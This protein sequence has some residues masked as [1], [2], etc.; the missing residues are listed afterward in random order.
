MQQKTTIAILGAGNIGISIANGLVQSGEFSS[1]QITLTRRKIHF[2]EEQKN[3]GYIIQSDN[4][5]AV[6]KSKIIIISVEPQQI[7][8]VL[9][10]IRSELVPERHIVISVVTGVWIK[11]I[12]AL[13]GDQISVVRAMPN[14]AI[15]IRKS[16]TCL[17]SD[18]TS[19]EALE[20]AKSIFD[21]VGETLV[22]EEEQMIAATALGA[23]GIAFF[24]R[25]IRAASQGGIE[26]GFDS[27]DALK[28]AVQAALGAASLL[29]NTENHPEYEI[30]K[31]TT[32]RGC[33]I[34]GLNQMEQA[35]FSAAMIKGITASA[36]KASSLYSKTSS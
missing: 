29:L 15:S 30:D 23:C 5:E 7:N 19:V 3:K 8:N 22:M 16:M 9:K 18:E 34:L 14:T 25:A 27:G 20:T 6:K 10:E 11:Q 24:L 12:S 35:G 1:E 28:I 2:L 21:S 17:S 31:V 26:I 13:I 36:D 33:T 32:P 4:C